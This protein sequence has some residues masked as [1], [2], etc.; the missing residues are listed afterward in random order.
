M[1]E[2]GL[3]CRDAPGGSIKSTSFAPGLGTYAGSPFLTAQ[4]PDMVITTVI[5][6]DEDVHHSDPLVAVQRP[7]KIIV[8][9]HCVS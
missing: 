1:A 2:S 6:V 4:A 3:F 8:G 9:Q 5:L 7:P